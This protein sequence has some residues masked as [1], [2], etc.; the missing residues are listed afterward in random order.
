MTPPFPRVNLP[1]GTLAL[2]GS[3]EYLPR[4]DQLDGELLN[5]LAKP[6]RVAL[7][8]TGAGTEGAERIAYWQDLGYEHFTRLGAAE[9]DRVPVIDRQTAQ[10]ETLAARVAR[11]NFVYISGGKPVHLYHSLVD[12]PVWLAIQSVLAGGGVVAG[13]SAGAMIFAEILPPDPFHWSGTPAFG[14]LTGCFILPHFDEIPGA[15]VKSAAQLG[16]KRWLVG[17]E[18]STALVCSSE[19]MQVSGL[20]GVTFA[21]GRVQRRFTAAQD[22][23][24]P[25][26][27]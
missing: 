9:V 3:G 12:T 4:V 15:L 5:R 22:W 18:G 1:G 11:A 8:A 20:G 27:E 19:G 26:A 16:G 21:T 6:E 25:F 17:I 23:I 24:T 14:L 13:C 2:V 10:D 7:L